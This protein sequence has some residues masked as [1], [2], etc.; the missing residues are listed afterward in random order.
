MIEHLFSTRFFYFE[1]L[2]VSASCLTLTFEFRAIKK[3]TQY[4]KMKYICNKSSNPE[5]F[6]IV[7]MHSF[8]ANFK[9]DQSVFTIHYHS[10][11]TPTPLVAHVRDH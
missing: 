4:A 6:A 9:F 8:N 3:Y 7:A 10:P 5:M 11:N 1:P 2:N